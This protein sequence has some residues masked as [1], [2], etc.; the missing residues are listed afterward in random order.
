MTS[1]KRHPSSKHPPT[2]H[3]R[4]LAEY[5]AEKRHLIPD[6]CRGLNGLPPYRAK[7]VRQIAVETGMSIRTARYWL[8]RDHFDEWFLWWPSF[9]AI[10]VDVKSQ[11]DPHRVPLKSIELPDYSAAEIAAEDAV[12]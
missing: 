7:S 3:R 9:E 2:R 12:R 6:E 4:A 10:L 8:E 1:S 5:M 11:R